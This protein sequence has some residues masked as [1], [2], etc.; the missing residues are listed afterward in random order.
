M[1]SSV[2]LDKNAEAREQYQRAIAIREKLA[3][4]FPDVPEYRHE[5][6]TGRNNLGAL[7]SGLGKMNEARELYKQALATRE[8]LVAEF[9][10]MQVHRIE[11]GG[12]YCNIGVLVRTEGRADESL[13]WFEKDIATLTPVHQAEP[14]DIWTKQFLR[15]SHYSRAQAYDLLQR[16]ADAIK[17]WDRAVE[18]SA[19]VDQPNPR[20]HRAFSRQLAGQFAEAV[21]E[22]AELTKPAPDASG[23]EK[24]TAGQWYDFACVYS[25]ASAKLAD[26][27]QEYADRAMELLQQAVKAGYTDAVH[28]KKDADLDPLRGREDFKKLLAELEKEAAR[29]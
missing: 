1:Y 12:T 22:V 13:S 14:R 2:P 7:L 9:P 10:A 6:A 24:W 29:K 3:A 21:A 18:L 5:L 28:I 8:K 16:Y 25:V 27:K 19:P 17:D 4:E 15:N 20:A 23:S 11:L 26:K